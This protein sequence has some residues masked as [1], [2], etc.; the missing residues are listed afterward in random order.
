MA[1]QNSVTFWADVANKY[2]GDGR[3]IFELYNEP[4]DVSWDVW[5]ER[6]SERRD[7]FTVA[8]CNSSTTRFAAPAPTTSSSSAGSTTPMI[9]AA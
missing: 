1:D 4:P 5:V 8:G 3:V 7:G 6:R 2:K 9:S